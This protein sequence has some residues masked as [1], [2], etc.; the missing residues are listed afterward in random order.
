M[1]KNNNSTNNKKYS[2]KRPDESKEIGILQWFHLGE[3][4]KVEQTLND[5]KTI[6]IKHLRTG[7]SWAD[8]YTKEGEAWYDWLLP[9]LSKEVEILP[10]FLY[11]PPSIG[12]AHKTSS[13]PK[14]PKRFA[15]F[16]DIFINRYGEHFEWVELW[17]EPNNRSE[18][19]YTLDSNWDIFCEMIICA[20]YWS[21]HL[22]K[23]VALG[24]MSPIDVNWLDFMAQRNVLENV[25][26][27]GIH[28]FPGSFDSH[29][30]NWNDQIESVQKVLDDHNLQ[31]EIWITE[32]GFS[33]WQYDEK[34]QLQEFIKVINS[35]ATR[36]YWYSLYDLCPS[37]STVDGFH[38]DERE[39]HFGLKDYKGKPKLLY[40]MMESFDLHSLKDIDWCKSSNPAA[41]KARK[42]TDKYVLVTG[43]A[44]FIGVNLANHL[45]NLGHKVIVY[46]NLSRPGVEKNLEWLLSE[47]D[48]KSIWVEI[49]DIRNYFNLKKAVDHACMI[50]HLAGQVA[51]TTSLEDPSFDFDVNIRGTFN[52]LEA[53]RESAHQPPIIFT[54]TNKV[55]GSLH[56]VAFDQSDFRYVPRDR[57]IQKYG[58]SES[59]PLDFHS[60]YGSS[61]G[62]AEQYVLDYARSFDLKA[63]VFR[64]S[65]I[66]GPHQFGTEDQGWVAHFL[67]NAIKEEMIHIYG[68]GKQV[69]DIL[70]IDDLVKAF[71]LAWENIEK[72]NGEAFNIGGGLDNSISL[73]ELVH[74]IEIKKDVKVDL[75]FDKVR[76][77]DQVYYISDYRKLK[78]AV[79]W[80]P[81]VTMSEGIDRLY[82]WLQKQHKPN[83]TIQQ[84]TNGIAS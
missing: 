62:S 32:A 38:L 23:K 1:R 47:H 43:G 13:P 54:S 83:I 34:Q 75:Q 56:D 72:I 31:P 20:A 19:D 55:Y 57:D 71:Q 49:A 3:Y 18:Y 44:G 26:A 58:I 29:F 52:V 45:L 84:L 2:R 6:G 65:C 21:K 8:Y 37:R 15:D 64:M 30:R 68:D 11:T 16:M 80:S 7:I 27:V 9:R 50:F 60:P 77:G 14:G 40:R 81:S 78:K 74:L 33:T 17:N 5:L 82:R 70:F 35:S 46:D 41:K 4:E 10:C 76:T 69:R 24:G 61:K 66:Y 39:Y 48:S 42:S 59:Q 73:L 67:I 79:G 51:V 12:I 22:G 25:D 63:V 53:I 36:V 28:G